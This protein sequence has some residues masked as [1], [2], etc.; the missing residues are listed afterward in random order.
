MLSSELDKEEFVD[1]VS[2]KLKL[3]ARTLPDPIFNATGYALLAEGMVALRNHHLQI[4]RKI[5]ISATAFPCKIQHSPVGGCTASS[6]GSSKRAASSWHFAYPHPK[7][8]FH[9]QKTLLPG[10]S[11]TRPDQNGHILK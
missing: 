1:V 7:R 9:Q 5:H 4:N 11:N 10:M 2:P 6:D 3:T 8:D